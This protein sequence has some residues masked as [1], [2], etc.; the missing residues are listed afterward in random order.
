MKKIVV[1]YL[2]LIFVFNCNEETPIDANTIINKSLEISGAQFID[3]SKI[4]FDFRDRKYVATRQ[5]G[6]FLLGRITIKDTDS[7]FDLLD[8]KGFERFV[9]HEKINVPDSMIPRYSSSIN[10]VHYFSVLPYGLN[11]KA[12]NKELLGICKIKETSYYK[13]KVTFNEIGGG[14]DFEDVFVYWVNKESFKADY[15]AYSY[16]D[17]D[18]VG[19]RFREAFNERYIEGVRFV[20]YN[21]YKPLVASVKVTELDSLFDLKE[22]RLLSQIELKNVEVN[23]NF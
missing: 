9:N 19:V 23:F 20:D 5:K 21:N 7:V 11:N 8:N 16:N 2:L 15:L 17:S 3:S 12:V 18:G 14:E 1:F 6:R 13:I 10:A 4:T 22:L